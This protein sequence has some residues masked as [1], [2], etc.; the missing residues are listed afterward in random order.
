MNRPTRALTCIACLASLCLAPAARAQDALRSADL[1]LLAVAE[2]IQLANAALC[3]RQAPALGVALESKDQFPSGKDPGFAA[4]VAFAV[5]LPDSPAA[6]AGIGVGDG[7]AAID[8]EAVAVRPALEEMPLRD[9]AHA[10]LGDHPAGTPL[11]LTIV[12][13]SLAREVELAPAQ[14]CRA[15][16]EV[17]V[18]GGDTAHSDGRVIQIA[19]GLVR[20]ASDEQ[21]AVIFAH[22]LAHG[23]LRHRQLLAGEGVSKG[24]GGEFGRSRRLNAE[25]EIEADRLSVH[26]LANAGYD[27]RIA[28]AFWRSDLGRDVGGGLFRSRIYASPEERARALEREIADFLAGGAPS[29]PGHLPIRR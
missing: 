6:Q 20:R 19:L 21:I 27:P 22:E 7:L 16:V 17:L 28:P 29:W 23:V 12:R 3:D 24:L 2:R 26:L 5:V 15:L 4:D 18:D 13:D 1:R 8:G 25:V 10:M 11:R 14:Q 9:S